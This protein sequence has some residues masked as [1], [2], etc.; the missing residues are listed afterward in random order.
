M[1]IAHPGNRLSR[2]KPGAIGGRSDPAVDPRSRCVLGGG[3]RLW[4]VKPPNRQMRSPWVSMPLEAFLS[5]CIYAVGA[6]SDYPDWEYWTL[7]LELIHQLVLKSLFEDAS[8]FLSDYLPPT[9]TGRRCMREAEKQLYDLVVDPGPTATYFEIKTWIHLRPHQIQRQL[10]ALASGQK[11]HYILLGREATEWSHAAI[12]AETNGRSHKIS[13]KEITTSLSK[14]AG[15]PIA[16]AY[17]T[18]LDQQRQ[19]IVK[20]FGDPDV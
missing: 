19:R 7:D 12:D 11:V 2:R 14:L 3:Y 1:R 18:A 6:R 15:L 5:R 17:R 13:Y 10:Q 4:P 9:T 20:S 8:S 16:D